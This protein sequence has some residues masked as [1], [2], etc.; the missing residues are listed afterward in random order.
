MKFIF[1]I[2]IKENCSEQEY[3]EAW[4]KGSTI[5]QK[6]QGAKGTKLYRKISEPGALIAI[7]DWESK[8]LRDVAMK[9]LDQEAPEIQVI[10][11]RHK[12]FGET[13]VLGNFEEIESVLADTNLSS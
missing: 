2:K 3:I 6:S 7:A 13:E 5:I 11:N 12:E 9:R 8:E 4:K 1:K 10:L